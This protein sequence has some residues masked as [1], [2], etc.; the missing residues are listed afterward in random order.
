LS[1]LLSG[2]DGALARL[3]PAGVLV[4]AVCAVGIIGYADFVTGNELSMGLF[5]VAPVALATWY[6][7]R[8]P[9]LAM[10]ALCCV[11]WYIAA[12]G[13]QVSHPFIPVWN[14]M[15]RLGFFVISALLLAAL[16]DSLSN[17]QHLARTERPGR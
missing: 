17:A 6:V 14:A 11:T 16:R 9:G 4:L 7:G 1:G 2:F 10:A 15:V 8:W 13:A 5:Y 3:S 12:Y